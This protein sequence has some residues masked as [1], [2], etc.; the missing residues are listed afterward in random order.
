MVD[1]EERTIEVGVGWARA[2][3]DDAD[4]APSRVTEW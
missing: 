2:N 1:I 4:F 3:H